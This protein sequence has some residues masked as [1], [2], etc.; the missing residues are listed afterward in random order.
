MAQYNPTYPNFQRTL[1]MDSKQDTNTKKQQDEQ[2]LAFDLNSYGKKVARVRYFDKM[3][4]VY[5]TLFDN[6]ISKK[7]NLTLNI[8]ELETLLTKWTE[9]KQFEADHVAPEEP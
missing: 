3:N 7:T 8:D 4:S 1:V 2:T 6:R 9:I 5:V